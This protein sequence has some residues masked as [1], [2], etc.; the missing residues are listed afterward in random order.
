MNYCVDPYLLFNPYFLGV[1]IEIILAA[2]LVGLIRMSFKINKDVTLRILTLV[3]SIIFFLIFSLVNLVISLFWLEGID[4]PIAGKY[5][6]LNAAVKNTCYLDPERKNCPEDI[7]GVIDIESDNFRALTSG[8]ILNY[9]YYPETHEYS[10][11]VIEK[12]TRKGVIFDPRLQK[13]KDYG[14]GGDF[15]DIKASVCNEKYEIIAPPPFF[16]P[17]KNF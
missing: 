13:R 11:V 3:F 16:G 12:D 6:V 14:Y 2:V 4:D 15:F 10:L 5:F 8:T 1:T 9:R 7:Q 17:W